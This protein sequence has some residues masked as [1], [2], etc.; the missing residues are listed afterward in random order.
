MNF[1]WIDLVDVLRGNNQFS[2]DSI[3]D[4]PGLHESQT[5]DE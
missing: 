5:A 2:T 4:L 3:A 1:E